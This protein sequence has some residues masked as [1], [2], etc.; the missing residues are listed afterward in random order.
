[1]SVHP[2]EIGVDV[3][4]GIGVLVDQSLVRA[5]EVAGEA[6]FPDARD[7]PGLRLGAARGEAEELE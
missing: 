6:R 3:L 2:D 1:M 4:D 7:D 5:E